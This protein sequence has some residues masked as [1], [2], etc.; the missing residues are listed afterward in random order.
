MEHKA[1]KWYTGPPR[2]VPAKVIY[3]IDWLEERDR[4]LN[5]AMDDLVANVDKAN[6]MFDK[7]D[8]EYLASE[9]AKGVQDIDA[10][11]Y[12]NGKLVMQTV[13]DPHDD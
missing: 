5:S 10:P 1:P 12:Y 11:Y 13:E 4:T 8:E 9:L 6:E 7:A 2:R 3:V